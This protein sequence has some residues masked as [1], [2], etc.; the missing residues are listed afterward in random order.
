MTPPSAFVRSLSCRGRTPSLIAWWR[1]FRTQRRGGRAGSGFAA[2]SSVSS[3][4]L[5]W[6]RSLAG[7]AIIIWL[8]GLLFSV[9]AAPLLGALLASAAII[10]VRWL[11]DGRLPPSIPIVFA[12]GVT[13]SYVVSTGPALVA[14]LIWTS[15]ALRWQKQGLAVRWIVLRL[16][17]VGIGLGA[18]AALVAASLSEGRLVASA[19]YLGPGAVTGVLMGCAFPRILWGA[20]SS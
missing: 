5:S 2:F 15:L 12:I 20:R 3:P 9:F 4:P 8:R 18:A 16:S 13:V 7:A 11:A 19:Q 6:V 10:I 17:V 1:S 14:G